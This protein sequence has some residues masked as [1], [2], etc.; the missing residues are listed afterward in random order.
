MTTKIGTLTPGE[1]RGITPRD[2]R[3]D[4]LLNFESHIR[5]CADREIAQTSIEQLRINR[6]EYFHS[7]R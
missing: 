6:P 2:V 1:V 7:Y 4:Q 5:H 3:K